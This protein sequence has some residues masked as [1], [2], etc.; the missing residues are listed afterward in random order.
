MTESAGDAV[1]ALAKGP[2][3]AVERTRTWRSTHPVD[4]VATLSVH[5]HGAYDP[6]YRV[7]GTDV[8]W[9]F[10]WKG[11]PITTRFSPR[12][13]TGEVTVTAW[14]PE[15][16]DVADAIL[17][18]A[19]AYLG[20]DDD[21]AG[22]RPGHPVVEHALRRLPGL[23]LGRTG[24]VFDAL[25]PIVL[26]QKVTSTEAHRGWSALVKRFG[27][28]APGPVPETGRPPLR[29]PPTADE[30]RR[31]PSW[32]WHR[33]GVGPQRSRTIVR[34]AAVA[35]RLDA[36]GVAPSD[37]ADALLRSLPGVG[38]WSSAEVR[39]RSHGDPDAV[40][41]GDANV[42]HHVA[43][44]LA[45]ERRASDE[46]LLELLEPWRGHRHRV[47]DLLIRTTPRPPRRASRAPIRDYRRM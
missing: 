28:P 20:A 12:P 43:W 40:S 41:V 25:V 19:P 33:C 6:A 5:R 1:R 36:A 35:D 44:V 15:R 21:L 46:R 47:C 10:R 13:H 38:V 11:A 34:V 7:V 45:G 30:W 39:Q 16:A 18:E 14:T 9:A 37:V 27:S 24:R 26:E 8:W 31:I 42:P 22:F 32:A 3:L 29:V 2:D 4:V 17:D 23:R